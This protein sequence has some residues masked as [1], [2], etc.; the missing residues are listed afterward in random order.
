MEVKISD[1]TIIPD[2]A[3]R[4]NVERVSY[5]VSIFSPIKY[6]NTINNSS[7][8][9]VELVTGNVKSNAS[10]LVKKEYAKGIKDNAGKVSSNLAKKSKTAAKK[11]NFAQAL[12]RFNFKGRAKILGL[13]LAAGLVTYSAFADS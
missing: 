6:K 8:G 4:N 5:P 3:V 1:I 9:I 12:K 11:I 2:A 7:S 10:S 13:V